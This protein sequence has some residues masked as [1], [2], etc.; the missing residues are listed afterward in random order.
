MA[1]GGYSSSLHLTSYNNTP[2]F[3]R[4]Y[5]SRT[6]WKWKV[7]F[8][9]IVYFAPAALGLYLDKLL[10]INE[11]SWTWPLGLILLIYAMLVASAAGRALRLCG[12]TREV[13]R[14]TPPDRLVKSGVYSCMR[15]PNQFGSTLMP[16]AISLLLGTPCGLALAGWGMFLGLLFILRIEEKLV[17]QEFCP[18]YCEYAKN[19]PAISIS[20]K[21]LVEA[22]RTW[23]GNIKC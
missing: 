6:L 12:H 11:L 16:L 14:F 23:R 18:E 1:A 10:G 13:K 15:H 20:P 22:I 2:R 3:K 21:C 4:C 5:W 7:A 8:W 17:H 19:V 9:I